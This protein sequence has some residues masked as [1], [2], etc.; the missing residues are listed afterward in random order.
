M[1]TYGEVMYRTTHSWPRHWLEHH[2]VGAVCHRNSPRCR[3]LDMSLDGPRNRSGRSGE[4][5]IATTGPRNQTPQ[6]FSQSLHRMNNIDS[7]YFLKKFSV[8]FYQIQF[9]SSRVMQW[10]N[11]TSISIV[12]VS[13]NNT[14]IALGV[15]CVPRF[16]LK[17]VLR[18]K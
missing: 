13:R 1:K 5:N 8:T 4:K 10:H 6:A 14:N 11:K 2:A 15:E 17:F 3:P 16:C 18:A 7:K 12:E 9:N